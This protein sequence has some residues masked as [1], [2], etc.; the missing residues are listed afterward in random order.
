MERLSRPKRYC[1]YPVAAD[2]SLEAHTDN[3][4]FP[5]VQVYMTRSA[6]LH[7]EAD[8]GGRSAACAA[9][10]SAE[11]ND[12][13]CNAVLRRKRL[14][15]SDDWLEKDI[16]YPAHPLE[17]GLEHQF[18]ETLDR[19]GIVGRAKNVRRARTRPVLDEIEE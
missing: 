1:K 3:S 13:A 17:T 6:G 8:C 9:L 11:S 10:M 16:V 18:G 2:K 14:A 19:H 7:N 5:T 15:R 12:A 4:F